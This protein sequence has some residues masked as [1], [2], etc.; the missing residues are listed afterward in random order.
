MI[1]MNLLLWLWSYAFYCCFPGEFH[2]VIVKRTG[3]HS[4]KWPSLDQNSHRCKCSIHPHS[5]LYS[6]VLILVSFCT[7]M[8]S[9]GICVNPLWFILV[10]SVFRSSFDPS[11]SVLLFEPILPHM[12]SVLNAVLMNHSTH[13]HPSN[14]SLISLHQP[15]STYL[16]SVF[17]SKSQNIP[18]LLC[19]FFEKEG[20]GQFLS[21]SRMSVTTSF[22][23]TWTGETLS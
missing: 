14:E 1:F 17:E 18:A 19:R 21:G 2:Q 10:F 15:Q 8:V 12:P 3:N 23:S 16:L 6:V 20:S 7:C 22:E 9:N 11:A 4:R 13:W 5:F